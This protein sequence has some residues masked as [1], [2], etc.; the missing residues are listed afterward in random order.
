M[1]KSG[2]N[3]ISVFRIHHK[4]NCY[5]WPSAILLLFLH[6]TLYLCHFRSNDV[7][8]KLGYIEITSRLKS[9]N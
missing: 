4:R 2:E 5:P 3:R 9:L 8:D 1:F 7:D 6:I